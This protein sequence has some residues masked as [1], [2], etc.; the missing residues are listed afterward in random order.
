MPTNP[1]PPAA[2]TSSTR[3]LAVSF[4]FPPLAYPRSI[5]VA[6]LVKYLQFETVLVCADER[7]ARRDPTLEPDAA[8]RLSQVLRVPFSISRVRAYGNSL[9]H[10]LSRPLWERWNRSPDQYRAWKPAVLKAIG[11]FMRARRYRP[12]ALATF[13]Q[14][15]IDHLIGLELKRALGVPWVAHFSDP[16]ADNPFHRTTTATHNLNLELERAVVSAADR[17]IFTS[18]ETVEMVMRKYPREWRE[19][20]RVLPQC[21]DPALFNS[22]PSPP[23]EG[24][25]VRYVGNF[26]GG[27]TPAPLFRTLRALAAR[28][29][30]SLRDVTFELV[31]ISDASIL[32]DSELRGLPAGI[33]NTSPPVEYRESLRLMSGSDG[34]L[35][36]DAPADVSVF[37]PSKLIDYIGAGRPVMGFTPQGAAAR[38]IGELGGWVAD[39][40]DITAGVETMHGFL[41]A[42]RRRREERAG[43]W[44][45]PAVRR[46]Y[47]ASF[48]AA[49]FEGIIRE[50]L[51]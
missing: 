4:A 48:L 25:T 44:G 28:A 1:A 9:A 11:N 50:L 34:L 38:L 30:E 18:E 26:Y 3:L 51:S 7:G 6:R 46:N 22:E 8:E 13:S 17:L 16:W 31:G 45:T 14:P 49:K 39:P 47:E 32:E 12:D 29:P 40:A 35:I 21:Y 36:I 43:T 24:L 42:L 15:N 41:D 19:R 10:H 37:L 33:I 2:D 5:Q 27:R 23:G 20:A